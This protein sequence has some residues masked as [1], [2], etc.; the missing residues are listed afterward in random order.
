M[1]PDEVLVGS[2]QN[3]LKHCKSHMTTDSKD[4]NMPSESEASEKKHILVVEDEEAVA[5]SLKIVL[6][7]FGHTVELAKNG[8]QA[9]RQFDENKHDFIFTDFTMGKMTGI[10][11]ARAIKAKC[12][13]MP[14]IL[15]TA[16]GQSLGVEKERL[17]VLTRDWWC[18]VTPSEEEP[19]S[20]TDPGLFY[21]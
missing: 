8:E 4:R 9:L 2:L 19:T 10:E 1:I 6:M 16:Y 12:P 13:D 5:I 17:A 3:F 7:K 11:L 14:I 15:V 18:V 21:K 20:Q